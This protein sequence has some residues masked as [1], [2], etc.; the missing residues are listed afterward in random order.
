[1]PKPIASAFFVYIGTKLPSKLAGPIRKMAERTDLGFWY[2]RFGRV[3]VVPSRFDLLEIASEILNYDFVYLEFGV[4]WGDSL[5]FMQGLD[6]N[7]T[8]EMHGFDTFEGLHEPHH[9]EISEGS[10]NLFGNI[11]NL[12]GVNFHKGFFNETFLGTESFLNKRLLVMC[13]ADLFSS[14][15]YVLQ[16][17]KPSLKI[18]DLIYFDDL[19]IP[20]QE[21]QAV[22]QAIRSGL[23]L[24]LIARSYEGRSALF[25]V[26]I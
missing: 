7:K 17:I 3:E 18:D 20:N 5:K 26:E 23:K 11:P 4:A 19:H 14:T 10:F 22:D 12:K 25:K 21:R 9:S 2:Q 15:S 13:D 16:T 1:M 6:R 8:I 24:A